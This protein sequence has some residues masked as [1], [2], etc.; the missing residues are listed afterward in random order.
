MRL[1]QVSIASAL[2]PGFPVTI[3]R[4]CREHDDGNFSIL[5]IEFQQPGNL[6][7]IHYRQHNVKDNQVRVR[8]AGFFQPNRTVFGLDHLLAVGFQLFTKH[9]SGS[10]IIFNYQYRFL[11]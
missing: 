4:P 1:D 7:A 6:V 3:L 9:Y 10:F 5:F 11:I 2:H 8:M